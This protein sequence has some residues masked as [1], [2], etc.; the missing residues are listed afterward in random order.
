M[1]QQVPPT[2]NSVNYF[3]QLTHS[4]HTDYRTP[5]SYHREKLQ[6]AVRDTATPADRPATCHGLG[7]QSC[8]ISFPTPAILIRAGVGDSWPKGIRQK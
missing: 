8:H 6:R 7:A 2:Y 4:G 1:L 3:Q 5:Q